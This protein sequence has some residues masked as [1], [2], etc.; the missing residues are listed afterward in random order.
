MTD[1]DNYDRHYD[2][3]RTRAYNIWESQGR[4]DGQHESHWY[5]ALKELGLIRP[6]EQA[7]LTTAN[8]T[9]QDRI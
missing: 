6:E 1:Q 2:A 4:P 5:Q 3:V 9:K 7:D 8:V